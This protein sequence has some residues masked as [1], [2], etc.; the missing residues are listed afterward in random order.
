[1]SLNFSGS[2]GIESKGYRMDVLIDE[3]L[4]C[5]RCRLCNQRLNP[6]IGEGDIDSPIILVGEAPGRKEDELGRPF[7]GLAGK[8]LDKLLA[9]EGWNRDQVYI[10]NI[11]KCRPPGN[12]R[13]K[14]HEIKDCAIHLAKQLE[15][16]APRVIAPMGN[17]ASAF[18]FKKVNK[19]FTSIG[20]EHGKLYPIDTLID[21]AS[22]YPLY[23]PAA[24]LYNRSLEDGMRKDFQKLKKVLIE[25][26]I[27]SF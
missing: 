17:L 26:G 22:L 24:V 16:I 15:I 1:L 8:F 3:V 19:K 12:R 2:I 21:G 7:V 13:P 23:H 25:L 9:Q 5:Q 4:N 27:E 6:V 14:A 18:F 11:V 20:N 10:T